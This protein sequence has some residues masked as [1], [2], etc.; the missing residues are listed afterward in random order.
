[1]IILNN[2]DQNKMNIRF[3]K[4][5]FFSII[6]VS[7]VFVIMVVMTDRYCIEAKME[8][9]SKTLYWYD[10]PKER[11][12]INDT[13][14][15]NVFNDTKYPYETIRCENNHT[16]LPE[17]TIIIVPYRSRLNHLKLFLSPLHKHLIN[18]V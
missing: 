1:M 15:F 6:V 16:R 18:Q 17:K 7:F 14:V 2:K 8:S 3:L 5:L 10:L 13:N 11:K 9:N 4:I 12:M